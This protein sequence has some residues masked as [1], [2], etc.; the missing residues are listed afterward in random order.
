MWGKR[1]R[2]GGLRKG[3]KKERGAQSN[4]SNVG[5]RRGKDSYLI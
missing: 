2:K 1:E 5:K 4:P 3:G